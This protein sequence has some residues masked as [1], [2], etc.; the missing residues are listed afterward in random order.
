MQRRHAGRSPEHCTESAYHGGERFNSHTL[1]FCLRHALQA[2][3]TGLFLEGGG[4]AAMGLGPAEG[5]SRGKGRA[6]AAGALPDISILL[7]F[8]WCN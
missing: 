1:T 5:S 7:S 3:V 8:P 4:P 2:D 6:F